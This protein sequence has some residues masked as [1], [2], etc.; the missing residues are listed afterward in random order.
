MPQ[1]RFAL[2][3]ALRRRPRTRQGGD[4][5]IWS[6]NH[7]TAKRRKPSRSPGIKMATLTIVSTRTAITTPM[8][9]STM[10]TAATS[11]T[12]SMTSI[13]AAG[14]R[15]RR[16]RRLAGRRGRD[17]CG[18]RPPLFG[19]DTGPGVC[20][21]PGPV[22][23]RCC[24]DL[25]DGIRHRDHG[26]NHRACDRFCRGAAVERGARRRVPFSCAVSSSARLVILLAPACCSDTWQPSG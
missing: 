12:M 9:T 13:A 21:R 16:P 19:R 3:R 24:R 23:C 4:F 2:A 26:D 5:P 17:L 18:R 7:E 22:A 11:M 1:R 14:K 15:A 8:T 20:P 10:M 6:Q 25:C